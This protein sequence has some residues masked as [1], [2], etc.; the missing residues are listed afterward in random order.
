MAKAANRMQ[1]DDKTEQA[2]IHHPYS[3]I[4]RNSEAYKYF[5]FATVTIQTN[6]Y[7]RS[8]NQ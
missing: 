8:N 6:R 3:H 5:A 4:I 1:Y 7:Q 2:A